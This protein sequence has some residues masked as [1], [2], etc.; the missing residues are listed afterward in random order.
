MRVLIIFTPKVKYVIWVY[1]FS[2]CPKLTLVFSKSCRCCFKVRESRIVLFV[3]IPVL[4][5]EKCLATV[6]PWTIQ[7]KIKIEEKIIQTL[8]RAFFQAFFSKEE[9]KIIKFVFN[10]IQKF[11][12]AGFFNS[13]K[14]CYSRHTKR[15]KSVALKYFLFEYDIQKFL[16][17]QRSF[18]IPIGFAIINTNEKITIFYKSFLPKL[19]TF[20]LKIGIQS[21]N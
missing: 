3:T 13:N 2:N 21:Q 4:Q 14:L 16:S 6:T 9:I 12:E 11:F 7:N 18:M 8:V 17:L 1:E 15:I 20:F 19:F 5:P 10:K